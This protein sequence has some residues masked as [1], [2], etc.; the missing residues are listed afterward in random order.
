LAKL[1]GRL[2]FTVY[3]DD[4]GELEIHS[5]RELEPEFEIRASQLAAH[6]Q[7]IVK[8][9]TDNAAKL[10]GKVLRY[11]ARPDQRLIANRKFGAN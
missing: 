2:S 6:E 8:D 3:M 11:I 1:I 4:R 10:S 7:S 5:S 9:A